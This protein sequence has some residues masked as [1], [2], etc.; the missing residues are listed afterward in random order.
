MVRFTHKICSKN[1]KLTKS[2]G[3]NRNPT[4]LGTT[5]WNQY[6]FVGPGTLGDG[7]TSDWNTF[8]VFKIVLNVFKKRGKWFGAQKD[9]TFNFDKVKA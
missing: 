1:F 3:P 8:S 4:D 9:F 7:D 5:G 6:S 2:V